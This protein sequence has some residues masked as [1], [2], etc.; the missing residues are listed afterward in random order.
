[1]NWANALTRDEDRSVKIPENWL[2]LH[3]YDA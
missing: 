3:Y 1:M 2:F